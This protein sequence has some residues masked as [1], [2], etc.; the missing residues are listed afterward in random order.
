MGLFAKLETIVT[1]KV[2]PG[3]G[4]HDIVILENG[5]Q[6]ITKHNEFKQGAFVVYFELGSAL[7][8]NDT[9]YDFLREHN[10]HTWYDKQG[11]VLHSVI[12]IN[13]VKID[14]VISQGLVMSV[15]LFPEL[16]AV[17]NGEDEDDILHV[18]SFF[19]VNEEMKGLMIA[20]A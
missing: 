9:R 19:D 14:D 16:A 8:A 17:M 4:N 10:L 13:A 15:S 3:N 12:R 5:K 7:P 2:V 6:V 18:R 20:K 11:K 1:I